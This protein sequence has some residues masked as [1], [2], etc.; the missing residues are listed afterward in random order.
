MQPH[1]PPPRGFK[2]ARRV[3]WATLRPGPPSFIRR[4]KPRG[5]KALG[6]RY[7]RKV[8]DH[9]EV[10]SPLPLLRSPWIEFLDEGDQRSRWCQPDGI[11]LDPWTGRLVL[12][13]VK[14]QHTADAWWQ[15]MQL[16]APV[17]ARLLPAW[18]I[19]PVEV[20]KWYDPALSFPVRPLMLP[21][22][23]E[24]RRDALGVHI[25]KP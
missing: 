11:L 5:R 8:L 2:P 17:V 9:L 16:Y 3:T 1:C 7:E 19:H 13:E 14:Y 22:L 23:E 15:L 12:L 18:E 4:G 21:A 20:C 10:E 24:A 6:L 25:L